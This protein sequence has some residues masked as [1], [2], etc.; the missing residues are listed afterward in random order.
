M[1]LIYLW[2]PDY[3]NGVYFSNELSIRLEL[4]QEQKGK[5]LISLTLKLSGVRIPDALYGNNILGLNAVVGENGSGKTSLLYTIMQS[6]PV[7]EST[8]PFL[9]IYYDNQDYVIEKNNVEI[10]K[11]EGIRNV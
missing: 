6:V 7:D 9:S 10:D 3:C 11:I 5:V 1:K 8:K 4:T 2:T